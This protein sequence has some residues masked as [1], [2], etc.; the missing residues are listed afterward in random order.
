MKCAHFP[1][2]DLHLA[3]DTMPAMQTRCLTGFAV[4]TPTLISPKGLRV[5]KKLYVERWLLTLKTASTEA[6]LNASVRALD[7]KGGKFLA[8]EVSQGDEALELRYRKG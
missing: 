8:F 7:F 6:G 1:Q 3:A 5:D 4:E 2:V